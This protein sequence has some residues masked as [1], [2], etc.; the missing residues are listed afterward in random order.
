M[1]W[2]E[3]IIWSD[4]DVADVWYSRDFETTYRD[5]DEDC[6]GLNP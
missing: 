4:N 5:I 3:K 2:Y 6:R 1:V